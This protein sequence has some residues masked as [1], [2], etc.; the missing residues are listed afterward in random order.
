MIQKNREGRKTERK[1]ERNI[2]KFK[3]YSKYCRILDF[4]GNG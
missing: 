1:T 3:N 4:G 2:R